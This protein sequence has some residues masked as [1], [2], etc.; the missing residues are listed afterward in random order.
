MAIASIALFIVIVPCMIL[1]ASGYRFSFSNSG[2]VST[3]GIFVSLSP[4]GSA[5]SVDGKYVQSTGLFSNSF[6]EQDLTPGMHELSVA[7]DGY[8][9]WKKDILVKPNEVSEVNSL[10][11]PTDISWKHV[12][13]DATTSTTTLGVSGDMYASIIHLFTSTSTD[14]YVFPDATTTAQISNGIALWVD[15]DT[16]VIDRQTSIL[17]LP[18]VFCSV[19]IDSCVSRAYI[20]LSTKPDF[21]DFYPNRSDAA[22][23][24]V[25]P[26]VSVVEFDGHTPRLVRMIYKGTKPQVRISNGSVYIRDGGKTFVTNQLGG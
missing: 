25:G 18:G 14:R 5:F 9:T 7:R 10:L 11:M 6:F 26:S 21:V 2:V 24:A 20:S 17:Q 15:D 1:Y 4:S 3:G 22:I 13:V 8:M 16:L 12:L 19:G 23:I